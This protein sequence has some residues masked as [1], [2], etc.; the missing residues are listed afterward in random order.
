[1]PLR[2]VIALL[3]CLLATPAIAGRDSVLDAEQATAPFYTQSSALQQGT[4]SR[5]QD[6]AH[7]LEALADAYGAAL[8][9]LGPLVDSEDPAVRQGAQAALAKLDQRLGDTLAAAARTADAELDPD[10]LA[11]QAARAYRRSSDAYRSAAMEAFDRGKRRDGRSLSRASFEAKVAARALEGEVPTPQPLAPQ[12]LTI[13]PTVSDQLTDAEAWITLA[14]RDCATY[15]ATQ[16][17]TLEAL[18]TDIR[19]VLTEHPLMQPALL[20][21]TLATLEDHRCPRAP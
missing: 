17:A 15:D 20:V 14:L 13:L 19:E 16:Q 7:A 18:R 21:R 11:S 1:M 6:L 8:Q 2:F 12:Q 10:E 3:S 5:R 4:P 9:A